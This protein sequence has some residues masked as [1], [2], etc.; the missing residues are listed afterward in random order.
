[1]GKKVVNTFDIITIV[2][3]II[4]IIIPSYF[5]FVT[6]SEEIKDQTIIIFIGVLVILI[7]GTIISY[8]YNKWAKFTQI[9][10]INKNKIKTLEEHLKK[11]ESSFI[12]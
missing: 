11:I 6:S 7:I 12:L 3:G 4:T 2:I 5:F 1:M 9:I 10:Q 8:I